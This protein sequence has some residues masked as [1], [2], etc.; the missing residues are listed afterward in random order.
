MGQQYD[1]NTTLNINIHFDT[2]SLYCLLQLT[3]PLT[4]GLLTCEAHESTVDA[5]QFL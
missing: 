5:A 4:A 1:S 3:N 2:M